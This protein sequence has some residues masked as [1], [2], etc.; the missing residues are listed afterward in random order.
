[1][2]KLNRFD[3]RTHAKILSITRPHAAI[4]SM[5]PLKHLRISKNSG[6]GIGRGASLMATSETA[7]TAKSFRGS[8]LACGLAAAT[9][10]IAGAAAAEV[11]TVRFARQLGLGYL[12]L[13]V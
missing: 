8:V 13:Y 12:Q 2:P 1:M 11:Q 4:Q 9:G 6:I 5:L 10:L 3:R 7:P